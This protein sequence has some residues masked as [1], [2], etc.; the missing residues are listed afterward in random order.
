MGHVIWFIHDSCETIII[1]VCQL[2]EMLS[3]LKNRFVDI[4][5]VSA[6]LLIIC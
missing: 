5:V 6:D 4:Q 3:Y 2:P 1:W